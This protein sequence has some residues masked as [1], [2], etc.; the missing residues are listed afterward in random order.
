MKPLGKFPDRFLSEIAGQPDAI[1]RAA[2]GLEEQTTAL[3]KAREAGG[4]ASAVVFTGM[5]ASYNACYVPVTLLTQR[6]V[7]AV[8]VDS[9]ELL[10]FRLP[11]LTADTLLVC[12]SQSGE[13][14][15]PVALMEALAERRSRPTVVSVTNGLENRIARAADLCLDM[16]TGEEAGPSTMTFAASLTVLAALFSEGEADGAGATA[17]QLERLLAQ[18]ETDADALVEWLGERPTLALLGRGCARA[19]S[20]T[21]A[22][23]L[24]EAAH[25]AAEALEAGQ[26]RHGPIELAGPGLAAIVVATEPATRALDLALAA[27]LVAAGAA[28]LVAV[29]D[30][31]APDGARTLTVGDVPPALAPAVAILPAQL[32]AWRLA[33][34]RGLDPCAFAVGSK[35]TTR[36]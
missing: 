28:V 34:W 33:R 19:A 22:L 23:V 30:G 5:G 9:A 24:K 10:H 1:R 13:S 29:H 27:D 8:I 14:A 32:I 18:P 21:G 12:V 20:E 15:E 3:A 35:V 16:C 31:A 6:G 26:F 4:R 25:L 7:H 2:A 36:E 11:T 17:A